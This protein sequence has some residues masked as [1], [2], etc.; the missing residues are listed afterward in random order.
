MLY[1]RTPVTKAMVPGALYPISAIDPAPQAIEVSVLVEIDDGPSDDL[2]REAKALSSTDEL[3][4]TFFIFV[5]GDSDLLRVVEQAV[6]KANAIPG[7]H[8]AKPHRPIAITP[9]LGGGPELL[10]VGDDISVSF[11]HEDVRLRTLGLSRVSITVPRNPV[12][13]LPVLRAAAHYFWSL[14][15]LPSARDLSSKIDAAV[16]S[17]EHPFKDTSKRPLVPRQVLLDFPAFFVTAAATSSDHFAPLMEHSSSVDSGDQTRET[18]KGRHY[19]KLVNNSGRHLYA[20]GLHFDSSTLEISTFPRAYYKQ[21]SVSDRRRIESLSAA[22]YYEG[23]N[24]QPWTTKGRGAL[25]LAGST[26]TFE[27]NFQLKPTQTAN[28]SALRFILAPE[29]LGL[30]DVEQTAP[31]LHPEQ[32]PAWPRKMPAVWD[33]VTLTFVQKLEAQEA[34][35]RTRGRSTS[36]P[37]E[38]PPP[39]SGFPSSPSPTQSRTIRRYSSRSSVLS[40][41]SSIHSSHASPR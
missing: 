3:P 11:L 41:H 10:L 33:A 35:R 2:H 1:Y 7:T 22:N 31:Y 15:L 19:I 17:Q 14:R 38:P 39:P 34:Q 6:W 24:T 12:S 27:V 36:E 26:A 28:V 20:W 29:P 40:S 13:I 32:C 25:L 16:Y 18:E 23:V 4:D 9:A 21:V 30:S 5:S 8:R 37:L